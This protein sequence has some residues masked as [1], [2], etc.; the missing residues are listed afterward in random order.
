MK[1]WIT[2][3]SLQMLLPSQLVHDIVRLP[4]LA[5]H[6]FHHKLAEKHIPFTDFIADHYT[7][8]EHHDEDQDNHNNLPFHNHHFN[9]QQSIFILAATGIFSTALPN[10]GRPDRKAKTIARQYFYAAA[11]LSSIWRPPKLA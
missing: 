11:A 10:Y 8:H 1:I 3:L 6:Y 5:A 4:T 7:D 9:F 2:V